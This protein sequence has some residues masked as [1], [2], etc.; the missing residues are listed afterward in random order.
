MSYPVQNSTNA[1]ASAY[2]LRKVVG[3]CSK[4][5]QL[6][7]NENFIPNLIITDEA[8]FRLN[9]EVNKQNCRIWASE[10][11][12]KIHEY[13]LHP[14]KVTVWCGITSSRI[15]GPYFLKILMS[16]Q[17]LWMETDIDKCCKSIFFVRWRTWTQT[18]SASY[19]KELKLILQGKL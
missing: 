7:D 14:L 11:P 6:A 17:W 16:I 9:G 19:K 5:L 15:I 2:G 10:N 13:P 1:G 4:I 8:D 3:F 18:I 12:R